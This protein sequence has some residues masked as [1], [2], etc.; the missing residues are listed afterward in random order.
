MSAS[1]GFD[2][3]LEEW[4]DDR[5]QHPP[6]DFHATVV[7]V[8][9]GMRQRPRW[10]AVLRSATS[11]PGRRTSAQMGPMLRVAP[12]AILLVL[13]LALLALA[14]WFIGSTQHHRPPPFGPAANGSLLYVREEDIYIADPAVP[15][16]SLI[17]AGPTVDS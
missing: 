13:V 14:A 17:V 12:T 1:D 8:V 9:A 15:G 16:E 3:L 2:R 11:M 10:I 6:C 5:A 4:L 7:D